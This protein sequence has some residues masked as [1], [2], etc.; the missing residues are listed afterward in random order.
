VFPKRNRKALLSLAIAVAVA[1][2]AF[3]AFAMPV[4]DPGCGGL[5]R[6]G[7]PKLVVITGVSR[8]L[9][10]AMAEEFL[11]KVP[12]GGLQSFRGP[13]FRTK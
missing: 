6:S 10:R 13:D 9:G 7:P 2:F 5:A 3:S 8:G 12:R 4:P 11:S 1:C